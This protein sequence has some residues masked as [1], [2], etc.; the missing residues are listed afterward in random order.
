MN[1]V[2]FA[3][4]GQEPAAARRAAENGPRNEKRPGHPRRFI[5]VSLRPFPAEAG[6]G[7]APSC[8]ETRRCGLT[9][10]TYACPAQS[11]IGPGPKPPNLGRS[12][13][14][15]HVDHEHERPV[16][17][18]GLSGA[19]RAVAQLGRDDEQPAA[20]LLHADEALVPAL[21]NRALAERDGERLAG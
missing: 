11:A 20:A 6:L 17:L 7:F 12:T 13:R 16:R 4:A 8:R 15:A 1:P 3:L 9:R 14:L 19:L 18:D 21:D 2:V 5:V 10:R